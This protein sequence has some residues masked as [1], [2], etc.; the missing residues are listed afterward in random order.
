[1]LAHPTSRF[2]SVFA[3][4]LLGCLTL[5][6]PCISPLSAQELKLHPTPFSVTLD[7]QAPPPTK[8]SYPIWMEALEKNVSAPFPALS[9]NSSGPVSHRIRLRRLGHL[10][11]EILLRIF[12]D[13]LPGKQPFVTGWTE[14]GRQLYRSAPLGSGVGLPTSESLAIP[15]LELDYLEISVEG[16]GSNLRGAFLSTLRKY[17]GRHS[18]DFEPPQRVTAPFSQSLSPT[19]PENDSFLFGRVRATVSLPETCLS[20]ESPALFEFALEKIPQMA[21]FRFE[22]L[23]VEPLAPPDLTLNEQAP[24][25]PALQLPDLADPAYLGRKLPLEADAR[26]AYSGWLPAQY[27][28]PG[29]A[30]KQGLNRLWIQLQAGPSPTAIR[31]LEIEL[32]YPSP[33]FLHTLPAA[34]P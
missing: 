4:L 17:E 19:P 8:P 25:K 7:F 10:N 31:A 33:Q 23:G 32:K 24:G 14:S 27:V 22:L 20:S 11:P 28:V 26:F 2:R 12:F 15:V 3:P 30:L 5:G 16:D 1:M 29:S 13:D 18:L 34:R 9:Q 6:T 21:V